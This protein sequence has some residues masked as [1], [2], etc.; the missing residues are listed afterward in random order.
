MQQHAWHEVLILKTS[1]LK[2]FC[3]TFKISDKKTTRDEIIVPMKGKETHL[4]I[5][6]SS[7]M[8]R[9]VGWFGTEIS[10]THLQ[11]SREGERDR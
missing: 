10:E 7:G 1:L 5:L 3:L 11:W 8:L 6:S 2:F 9:S 4:G